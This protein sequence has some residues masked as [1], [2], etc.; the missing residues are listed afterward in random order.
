MTEQHGRTFEQR[1]FV[2]ELDDVADT[3][4]STLHGHDEHVGW[5]LRWPSGLRCSCGEVLY[6]PDVAARR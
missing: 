1:A 4:K 6:R 3:L 2:N 5:S